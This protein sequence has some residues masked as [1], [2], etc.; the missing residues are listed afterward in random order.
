[1]L[2]RLGRGWGR[3]RPVTRGPESRQGRWGEEKVGD[4]ATV[5]GGASPAER[6]TERQT[7]TVGAGRRDKPG[8]AEAGTAQGP[9]PLP[10]PQLPSPPHISPVCR[11]PQAP[12]CPLVPISP[13]P[14]PALCHRPP[15]PAHP[16]P[17]SVPITNRG[18]CFPPHSLPLTHSPLGS[19]PAPP[20]RPPRNTSAAVSPSLALRLTS[21]EVR[22]WVSLCLPLWLPQ[23]YPA[24]NLPAHTPQPT[25]PTPGW[26]LQLPHRPVLSSVCPEPARSRPAPGGLQ[27]WEGAALPALPSAPPTP[28]SGP[29]CLP[30]LPR[31][32]SL[33]LLLP[34][35][36]RHLGLPPAGSPP[37]TPLPPRS[38]SPSGTPLLFPSDTPVPQDL[39]PPSDTPSS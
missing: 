5:H 10:R 16:S 12:L 19:Q 8:S 3:S 1:M 2:G 38:A 36:P 26:L 39:P 7:E 24:P 32:S 33:H 15:L 25:R 35:D 37:Q 13:S 27:G 6:A 4:A 22:L 23:V 30:V 14:S 21:R 29:Q 20:A 34:S 17:S 28:Q 9:P 18:P 31:C 11:L